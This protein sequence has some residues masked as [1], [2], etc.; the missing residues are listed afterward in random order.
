MGPQPTA[1]ASPTPPS[2]SADVSQHPALPRCRGPPRGNWS[3]QVVSPSVGDVPHDSILHGP[4]SKRKHGITR[5]VSDRSLAAGGLQQSAGRGRR[6]SIEHHTVRY[7]PR[8]ESADADPPTERPLR[9]ATELGV[10]Q[11]RPEGAK[12]GFSVSFV[13]TVGSRARHPISL[14]MMVKGYWRSWT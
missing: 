8:C 6:A 12:S 7:R 11:V 1:S 9:E 4:G 14:L 13:S 5:N 10:V 2:A 3:S